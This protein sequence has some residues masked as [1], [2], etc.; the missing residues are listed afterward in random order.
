MPGI[1]PFSKMMAT[2]SLPPASFWKRVSQCRMTP[3][4]CVLRPGVAKHMPR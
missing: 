4:M 3:E 1:I 2:M